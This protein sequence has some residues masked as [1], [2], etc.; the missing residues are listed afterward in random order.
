MKRIPFCLMIFVLICSLFLTV[1]VPVV[2]AAPLSWEYLSPLSTA[3]ANHTLTL[4]SDGRLLVAGGSQGSDSYLSSTAIYDPFRGSWSTAASMNYARSGHTANLLADGRVLVAGGKGLTGIGV[5]N[6]LS[7][8][9]IYD[10]TTN[11][12][13]LLPDSMTSPRQFHTA[14]LLTDG[15]VLLAGGQSGLL[16]LSDSVELFDPQ[17]ETFTEVMNNNVLSARKDHTATRLPDGTVLIA[18]GQTS[19]SGPMISYTDTTAI[20]NPTDNSL[21][22]GASF[23]GHRGAHTA[24]LLNNGKVLVAGGRYYSLATAYRTSVQLYDPVTENWSDGAA[25]STG[26]AYH[27]TSLQPNGD[28]LVC[29]GFNGAALSQCER[30]DPDVNTWS[31]AASFNQARYFHAVVLLPSG[32]LVAVGGT[33]GSA[34]RFSVER[35]DPPKG[36]KQAAASMLNA[37]TPETVTRLPNGRL[38]ITGIRIGDQNTNFTEIYDVDLNIWSIHAPMNQ[39][40]RYHTATLLPDGKVLVIGGLGETYQSTVL[41]TAEIYDPVE[42]TWTMA[43]SMTD[44]R[45]FHTATLLADGR[46]MVVGG[47]NKDLMNP[48]I[49]SVEIYNPRSNTWSLTA[50]PNQPRMYHNAL[51][52]NDGRVM[53]A[54]GLVRN[55]GGSSFSSFNSVE[56]FDPNNQTWFE[57]A[58][59]SNEVNND[60][61]KQDFTMTLLPD[62]RVLV[63]G[64]LSGLVYYARIERYDPATNTWANLGLLPSKRAGHTATLM[65]DGRVLLAGGSNYDS[66]ATPST[67]YINEYL[68]FDPAT[69]TITPYSTMVHARTGHKA[70]LL[71]NGRILILGGGMASSEYLKTTELYTSGIGFAQSWRPQISTISTAILGESLTLTG[72]QFFGFDLAEA[73]AGGTQ[74]AS[75]GYPLLLLYSLGNEQVHWLTP[76]PAGGFSTTA[77]TSV[78][79]VNFPAGPAYAIIYSNGIASDPVYFSV[80]SNSIENGEHFIYLPAIIR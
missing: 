56:I 16:T 31:S 37:I 49:A 8:A 6:F 3:R 65:G 39:I 43:A 48:A 4:L 69:A 60:Y 12:W 51:L 50:S 72:T 13:T 33:D 40:R 74:S 46:V 52:L 45:A 26:V 36:F 35:F 63:T 62:G 38:L 30:Y 78:P 19:L 10:P 15:R 34:A 22:V 18:G 2:D 55:A 77:F 42:E 64:G 44:A 66:T 58:P 73:S 20:F 17:D 28:L 61:G 25:L 23:S 80:D 70:V 14:T 41:N 59:M 9:E 29:G 79:L 27:S 76:D 21:S 67:T 1:R 71:P 54:G 24:T 68:I 32:S 57:A 53:I 75:S 7:N 47:N 11:S 5:A